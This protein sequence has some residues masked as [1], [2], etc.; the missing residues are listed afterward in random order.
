MELLL[1]TDQP[2]AATDWSTDGRFLVYR[3]FD[4]DRQTGWNLWALPME[5]NG[6]AGTPFPVARTNFDETNGQL[7]PDGKWVAYQSDE[8][9]RFEVYVQRFP[10]AGGKWPVSRNGGAQVR[11][12]RDG[13]ELFY[14]AADDRLMAVPIRLAP[15]GQSI[16]IATPAPLFTT[17]VGGAVQG[18]NRQQYMVSSDGQR[19]LMNTIVQEPTTP[20]IMVLNW[21]AKH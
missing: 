13:K 6:R 10:D 4:R 7:S 16:E 20:I 11:W 12:R 3:S 14:V 1:E 9:G 18:A 17:H 8:T 19:F 5:T 15:D 21:M 2:K